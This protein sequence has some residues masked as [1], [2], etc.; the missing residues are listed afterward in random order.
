MRNIVMTAAAVLFTLSSIRAE[1]AEREDAAIEYLMNSLRQSNVVFIRDHHAYAP[2]TAIRMLALKYGYVR[3]RI[4]TADQ[5]I[6]YVASENNA[7]GEL[8]MVRTADGYELPA[9]E[10]LRQKLKK[11]RGG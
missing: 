10:W 4:N 6:Q 3:K 2:E 5:F 7:T 8:Y 9:G 1:T 11:Y